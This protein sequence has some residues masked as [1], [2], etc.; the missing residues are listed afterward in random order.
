M[1]VRSGYNF[2]RGAELRLVV[3]QS[4]LPGYTNQDSGFIRDGR[5]AVAAMRGGR[6][7]LSRA[8]GP[9]NRGTVQNVFSLAG[10]SAA[11]DAISRE[12]PTTPARR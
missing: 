11:H 2:G 6:E 12:C 3:G 1:A 8:P 10:F 9:N 7:A 4:D 5:A